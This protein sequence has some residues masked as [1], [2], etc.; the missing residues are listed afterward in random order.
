MAFLMEIIYQGSSAAFSSPAP[1]A[2]Q[3]GCWKASQ[4]ELDFDAGLL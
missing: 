3:K 4:D 1:A 2:D